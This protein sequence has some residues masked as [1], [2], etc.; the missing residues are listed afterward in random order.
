MERPVRIAVVGPIDDRL[1]GD[2]RELP[3]RPEVRTWRSVVADAEALLRFQPDLLLAGF[4]DAADEEAGALRMLRQLWPGLGVVVVATAASEVALAPLAARLHARLVVYPD[5]PG[6]LAAALE[7]ARQHSDRPRADVFVDLAR[8]IA[9]EV[10]NPLMF[11]AGHLQ[12]LR[13]GLQGDADRSRL[14]QLGAALAGLA[15]V[16]ATIDRLRALAQA[17]KGPRTRVPVD[18]GGLL[19]A[20]VAARKQGEPAAA[21]E[22]ADGPHVV[23]GDHEQLAP[24]VAAIVQF[25]DELATAGAAVGLHLDP[26]GTARRLRVQARGAALAAWQLPATFE[27]YYPSRALRGHGSGLGLFLAQTVVLAHRGQVTASRLPDGALTVDFV[28]PE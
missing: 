5:G 27:P 2:L 28:L 6:Q 11:V 16:E 18:L 14:D 26:L 21:V 13:A 19:A 15:R 7:Q 8:G 17:A 4:A 25:A 12:L 3:L 10:N 24:A 9:D 23:R 20:A 1:P 22:V